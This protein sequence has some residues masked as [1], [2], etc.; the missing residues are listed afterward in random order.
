MRPKRSLEAEAAALRISEAKKRRQE[1]ANKPGPAPYG[2]LWSELDR[3][4]MAFATSDGRFL[5]WTNPNM[6]VT[7][8]A[9]PVSQRLIRHTYLRQ[10]S[11]YVVIP[12]PPADNNPEEEEEPAAA[13][14]LPLD[15]RVQLVLRR[16]KRLAEEQPSFGYIRVSQIPR[17][18]RHARARAA[19]RKSWARSEQAGMALHP[20]LNFPV[21][22]ESRPALGGPK[23]VVDE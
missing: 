11:M 14:V 9:T 12:D 22:R 1:R 19:A 21:E 20:D 5:V 2:L 18:P 7:M 15:G 17:T 16:N 23:E 3:R 6:S 8:S 10:P 4:A 13:S